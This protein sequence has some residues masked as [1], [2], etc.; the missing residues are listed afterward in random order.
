[1]TNP[2][3]P[4]IKAEAEE[5]LAPLSGCS[6]LSFRATKKNRALGSLYK[7]LFLNNDA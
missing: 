5:M 4:E 2:V 7:N 1:M 6:L 3:P